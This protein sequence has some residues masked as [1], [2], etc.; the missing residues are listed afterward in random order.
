MARNPNTAPMVAS[1]DI[2]KARRRVG[3]AGDAKKLARRRDR[4]LARVACQTENYDQNVFARC[5]G[6]DVD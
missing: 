1:Y 5:C 4:R 2:K 3:G 6:R